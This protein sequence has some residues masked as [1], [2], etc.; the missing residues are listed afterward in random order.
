MAFVIFS[1]LRTLLILSLISRMDDIFYT[2]SAA[3]S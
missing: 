2:I 3:M 1:V